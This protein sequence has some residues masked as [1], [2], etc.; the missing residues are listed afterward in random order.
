MKMEENKIK[1]LTVDDAVV[2]LSQGAVLVHNCVL[3]DAT[4]EQSDVQRSLGL[5]P[6]QNL[7]KSFLEHGCT[8]RAHHLLQAQVSWENELDTVSNLH[9]R[10]Q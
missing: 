4:P 8:L 10:V 6:V 2:Q 7:I 3:E 1:R 9:L 5:Q